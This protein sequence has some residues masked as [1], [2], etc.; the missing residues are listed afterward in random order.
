MW[1]N[2]SVPDCTKDTPC[3]SCGP[4]TDGKSEESET[5][6]YSNYAG[7]KPLTYWELSM[8]KGILEARIQRL[9]EKEKSQQE[10]IDSQSRMLQDMAR[11]A[12]A[13]SY[14]VNDRALEACLEFARTVANA[15]DKLMMT[16]TKP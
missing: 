2:H 10:V 15:K 9:M 6:K 16:R 12:L 5:T 1:F 14:I 3:K 13:P 4:G 11:R 8:A 7:L